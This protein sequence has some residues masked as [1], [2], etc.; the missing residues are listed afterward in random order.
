MTDYDAGTGEWLVE[1]LEGPTKDRDAQLSLPR[2]RVYL[3]AEDPM[4]FADRVA[5]AHARR[6]VN[7]CIDGRESGRAWLWIW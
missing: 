4:N 7:T 2:L 1:W 3:K 6:E 5:D